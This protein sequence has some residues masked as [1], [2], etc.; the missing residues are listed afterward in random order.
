MAAAAKSAIAAEPAMEE[1]LA[2]EL[3]LQIIS[4]LRERPHR[5]VELFVK[6]HSADVGEECLKEVLAGL[7][8]EKLIELS[9]DRLVRLS[10][11]A[12][13]AA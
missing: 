8:D 2:K 7:V 13:S 3:R 4:A 10:E 5:P 6:F 1:A 11:A 12:T 9:A